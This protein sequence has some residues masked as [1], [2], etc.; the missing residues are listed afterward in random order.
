M[1]DIKRA[2]RG[3]WPGPAIEP[4]ATLRANLAQLGRYGV[5]YGAMGQETSAT[6]PD[7]GSDTAGY[8]TGMDWPF[9]YA[10]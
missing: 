1:S 9:T 8:E 6:P 2:K 5:R 7:P 3:A 10:D 4:D